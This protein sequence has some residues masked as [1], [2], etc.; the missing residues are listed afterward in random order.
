MRQKRP[1]PLD[2]FIISENIL[3]RWTEKIPRKL[4]M[5]FYTGN[6]ISNRYFGKCL[7]E[8]RNIYESI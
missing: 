1:F 5:A 4:E 3:N 2:E 8:Q 7:E 6:S